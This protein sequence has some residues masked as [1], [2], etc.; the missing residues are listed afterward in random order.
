MIAAER[1]IRLHAEHNVRVGEDDKTTTE[2]HAQLAK[3]EAKK[4]QWWIIAIIL[5]AVGIAAIAVY[6]IK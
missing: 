1:V 5:A 3:Q 6:Y 4:E 2:M